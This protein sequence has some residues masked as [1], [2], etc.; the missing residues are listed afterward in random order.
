M[1]EGPT[2]TEKVPKCLSLLRSAEVV[3]G[4]EQKNMNTAENHAR[5]AIISWSMQMTRTT[6]TRRE[7]CTYRSV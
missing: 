4:N 2:W 3:S 5:S 7:I 1:R 6:T